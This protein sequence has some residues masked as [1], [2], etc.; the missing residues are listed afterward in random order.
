METSN[1]K[2][3]LYMHICTLQFAKSSILYT[4][5]SDFK[6]SQLNTN[7]WGL[8]CLQD[9]QA[10]RHRL[11][12]SWLMRCKILS[13]DKSV[14]ECVSDKRHGVVKHVGSSPGCP[15]SLSEWQSA[16][17]LNGDYSP[18]CPPYRTRLGQKKIHL[19]NCL[20][21]YKVLCTCY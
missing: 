9:S 11:N 17:L 15:K 20:G 4:W 1:E 8:L 19:R 21:N 2:I 10:F 12:I 16:H 18:H 6:Y 14:C 13:Y 7:Y 3:T 5:Q